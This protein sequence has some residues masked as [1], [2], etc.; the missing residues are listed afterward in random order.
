M[1]DIVIDTIAKKF[2]PVENFKEGS[3]FINIADSKLYTLENNDW[4][5]VRLINPG[6]YYRVK[7]L[8]NSLFKV[9][10][11]L[12]LQKIDIQDVSDT[13]TVDDNTDRNI[14]GYFLKNYS[15]KTSSVFK[16]NNITFS[17]MEILLPIILD[18]Y[19]AFIDNSN[20]NY[21]QG[22]GIINDWLIKRGF[23]KDNKIT[24][25]EVTT[26]DLRNFAVVVCNSLASDG[27]ASDSTLGYDRFLGNF[28]NTQYQINIKNVDKSYSLKDIFDKLRS[29][30]YLYPPK[31]DIVLRNIINHEFTRDTFGQSGNNGE[32]FNKLITKQL[33]LS[34]FSL[35]DKEGLLDKL[36]KNE[37]IQQNYKAQISQLSQAS[38]NCWNFYN[39]LNELSESLSSKNL[40]DDVVKDIETIIKNYNPDSLIFLVERLMEEAS[41]INSQ[42]K[43]EDL[44]PS[45]IEEVL[46]SSYVVFANSE[47]KLKSLAK[48][49][50]LLSSYGF[51]NYDSRADLK[52]NPNMY[53]MRHNELVEDKKLIEPK[54][55]DTTDTEAWR[56]LCIQ[57]ADI[58][59]SRVDQR[60]NAL[61]VNT[62]ASVA[63]SL[64]NEYAIKALIKYYTEVY[65][66]DYLKDKGSKLSDS[67]YETGVEYKPIDLI[68]E[69]G[70]PIYET[71][72]NGDP[73]YDTDFRGEVRKDSKGNPIKVKKVKY[74]KSEGS[75]LH[76]LLKKLNELIKENKP[77]I[78]RAQ[79]LTDA[80]ITQNQN[81]SL[82]MKVN[83]V[84][85]T[86]LRSRDMLKNIRFCLDSLC[87]YIS[88]YKDGNLE[89]LSFES[90]VSD[91]NSNPEINSLFVINYMELVNLLKSDLTG[92]FKDLTQLL[93]KFN[94]I[95]NIDIDKVTDQKTLEE[96]PP[97]FVQEA[98]EKAEDLV[99][100]IERATM[101]ILGKK[102][103]ESKL[104]EENSELEKSQEDLDT[105]LQSLNA[106]NKFVGIIRQAL[107]EINVSDVEDFLKTLQQKDNVMI[108]NKNAL[109]Q[110]LNRDISL[111]YT[112]AHSLVS[113]LNLS[114]TTKIKQSIQDLI[115]Q[116]EKYGDIFPSDINI[117]FV[118]L[119]FNEIVNIIEDILTEK[120]TRY[121]YENILKNILE[122]NKNLSEKAID[123]VDT[124]NQNLFAI[125]QDLKIDTFNAETLQAIVDASTKKGIDVSPNAIIG[126]VANK[127]FYK[128]KQS[129]GDVK[130]A[131]K[132]SFMEYLDYQKFNLTL[133]VADSFSNNTFS[134]TLK[135]LQLDAVDQKYFMNAA[136]IFGRLKNQKL[137][138]TVPDNVVKAMAN[139]KV[140]D[141]I[142]IALYNQIQNSSIL[143]QLLDD[144]ED[145]DFSDKLI[146]N[147]L[148]N[149]VLFDVKGDVI[150]AQ[151]SSDLLTEVKSNIVK[152]LEYRYLNLSD[153]IFRSIFNKLKDLNRYSLRKNAIA[154]ARLISS[155]IYQKGSIKSAYNYITES[156]NNKLNDKSLDKNLANE[157][158]TIDS[159][160]KTQIL[161][162]EN[163]IQKVYDIADKQLKETIP[164]IKTYIN[165]AISKDP[166]L[167]KYT[168][169][170]LK[171]DKLA[172]RY[173]LLDD[174]S[175]DILPIDVTIDY[176][177]INSERNKS[178][179]GFTDEEKKAV[180]KITE[181]LNTVYDVLGKTF[182]NAMAKN[183]S[184]SKIN[185]LQALIHKTDLLKT[186]LNDK[187]N[188]KTGKSLITKDTVEN[189][190]QTLK[191]DL[192]V[193]LMDV[194]KS[195]EECFD[196]TDELSTRLSDVNLK[197]EKTK[198]LLV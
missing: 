15:P 27:S 39:K 67:D 51:T 171:Y 30:D 178:L 32:E 138:R 49:K 62:L 115:A 14:V 5:E 114:D 153:N 149:C 109:S 23:V 96:L 145:W 165:D 162:I 9:N 172:D 116:A 4:I 174:S 159:E 52:V 132:T 189:K 35:I 134:N 33:T 151:N 16:D 102:Q 40:N 75:K 65:I 177:L 182:Y 22:L 47:E 59:R 139:Y 168:V 170:K 93:A 76:L 89:S 36:S 48:L 46:K 158:K 19:K 11:D 110:E 135:T 197:I 91:M 98:K 60:L 28:L 10:D 8:D 113:F 18:N 142:N 105:M 194:S 63:E 161:D 190:V 119:N 24:D 192:E 26:E 187:L 68:D 70:N 38:I 1:A 31:K 185:A 175:K 7:S 13:K 164:N 154:A 78:Q 143:K 95:E 196:L 86:D 88:D 118:K 79:A 84:N 2:P 74:E 163:L 184:D 179:S 94:D 133:D 128:Y 140:L 17:S 127:L 191:D 92:S 3:Q 21:K 101:N 107:K 123:P 81:R 104:V 122:E 169:I 99:S 125:F 141:Y 90:I 157:L 131:E 71:D 126:Y 66:K 112:T 6:E 121:S 146:S 186:Q 160:L 82:D 180:S 12:N 195:S 124:K 61:D 193:K 166:I 42:N 120:D 183:L 57:E 41:N 155:V 69:K 167:Q 45:E 103:S 72:I 56:I 176:A 25:K 44:D 53:R 80:I 50:Q 37:F 198:T 144:C 156:I 136:T 106:Y 58:D 20:L 73:V 100:Y 152:P 54:T 29:Q 43:R 87:A 111:L 129:L 148:P 64:R 83:N 147:V 130:D 85:T 181:Q 137:Y 108:A 97:V 173:S 55:L 77:K 150:D 188:S 117:D 34:W